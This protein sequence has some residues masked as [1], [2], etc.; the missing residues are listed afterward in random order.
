MA[1]GLSPESEDRMPGQLGT[2]LFLFKSPFPL[3][4]IISI[5]T[6]FKKPVDQGLGS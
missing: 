4:Y 1:G 2:H 3:M 6:K 5:Q